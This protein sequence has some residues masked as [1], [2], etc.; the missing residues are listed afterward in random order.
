MAIRYR[1][2]LFLVLLGMSCRKESTEAGKWQKGD[3]V[4]KYEQLEGDTIGA[5]G[6]LYDETS[7][8]YFTGWG[9]YEDIIFPG[10]GIDWSISHVAAPAVEG[11]S[12]KCMITGGDPYNNVF[13]T[14]TCALRWE[15][16]P[17]VHQSAKY[18]V[19]ELDVYIEGKLDCNEPDTATIEGLELTWQHIEIPYSHG[20]GVQFSKGG[21][22]R[23]WDDQMDALGQAKGW[24]SFSPELFYCLIPNQWH[25]IQLEGYVTPSEIVYHRM[26]I[27]E[28]VFDLTSARLPYVPATEGWVENFLQIGM[29]I[30]GNKA[31]ESAHGHGVDPVAVYLDNVTYTGFTLLEE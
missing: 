23:Y 8:L 29:Q 6:R 1:V 26:R 28:I 2:C 15:G 3:M 20:F 13:F 30:N 18:L 16:D 21:E 19:Y 17:W 11:A 14:N 22:W 31:T 4:F 12:L 5:E 10:T 27:D 24:R 25:H 7:A 9:V